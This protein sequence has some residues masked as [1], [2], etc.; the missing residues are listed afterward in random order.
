MSRCK[1]ELNAEDNEK[2]DRVKLL[3]DWALDDFK[4]SGPE[5]F[6]TIKGL[7]IGIFVTDHFCL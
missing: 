5:P 3:L 2:C 1:K 7:F 4:P 6:E